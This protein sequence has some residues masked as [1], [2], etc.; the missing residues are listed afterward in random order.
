VINYLVNK[1]LEKGRKA[2]ALFVDMKA[3]F[4][5]VNR[6]ILYKTMKERGIREGLI[7]RVKEVFRET[8]SRVKIGGELGE[9]FFP[10]E[11]TARGVRQRCPL[12]P[13]LF[14]IVI[15]DLEEVMGRVKWGG[16]EVEKKRIYSLAYADDIVLLA[17]DEEGMRS[18]IGR[19]EDYIEE[20]RLKLNVEKKIMRFKKGGGRMGKRLEVERKEN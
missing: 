19:L 3:A 6:R 16:I 12:S 10:R 1:Q 13:M 18:M 14:N 11:G 15:A 8:K 9:S 2:V 17:E 4:D 20:M 7:E 5:S